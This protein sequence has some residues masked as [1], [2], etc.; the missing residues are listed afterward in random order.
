[1]ELVKFLDRILKALFDM[2]GHPLNT[3]RALDLDVFAALVTILSLT[4]NKR[5]AYIKPIVERYIDTTFNSPMAHIQLTRSFS[6]LVN[7]INE[8]K[9]AKTI[10]SCMKCWQYIIRLIVKSAQL[11]YESVQGLDDF[12]LTLEDLFMVRRCRR[13][14]TSSAGS[15]MLTARTQFARSLTAWQAINA[16]VM[17]SQDPALISSHVMALQKFPQV[18]VELEKLF[19]VPAL[20]RIAQS[21]MNAVT[22][23]APGSEHDFRGSATTWIIREKM[24]AIQGLLTSKLFEHP[25]G[26]EMLL[27][28]LNAEVRLVAGW[29]RASQPR[30]TWAAPN[31]KR[32]ACR[33]VQ[34]NKYIGAPARENGAAGASPDK[35]K[36]ARSTV[37][38]PDIVRACGLCLAE[39][40]NVLGN[41]PVGRDRD[42]LVKRTCPLRSAGHGA[43]RAAHRGRRAPPTPRFPSQA[44]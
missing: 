31:W 41:L 23:T 3:T 17:A 5:L 32:R 34:L 14:Q 19:D 28:L 40:L 4:D 24:G 29:N 2:L 38:P 10:S 8:P 1:M 35:A 20:S 26:Q 21:F 25:N 27:V 15:A 9:N 16:N 6:T 42:A 11:Q 37:P 33:T 39:L 44:R 7:S 43:C 22:P 18:L 36:S 13:A 12:R 30:L